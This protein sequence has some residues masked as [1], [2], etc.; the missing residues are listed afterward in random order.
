MCVEEGHR[1]I[2]PP[3]PPR[4]GIFVFNEARL[5]S[6]RERS[7]DVRERQIVETFR[8]FDRNEA[9]ALLSFALARLPFPSYRALTWVKGKIVLTRP[10]FAFGSRER[11]VRGRGPGAILPSWR[12]LFFCLFGLRFDR[13]SFTR[14]ERWCFVA[15]KGV[16]I[17]SEEGTRD[18]DRR[19][20]GF[21]SRG[22]F[23]GS[24]G[25]P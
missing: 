10:P 13:G 24:F 19:S 15:C 17:G 20:E 23:P 12:L 5:P 8:S 22:R 4:V 3:V 16:E 11:G 6:S 18:F 1:G 25:D 9:H 2:P 21:R 7:A 14:Q